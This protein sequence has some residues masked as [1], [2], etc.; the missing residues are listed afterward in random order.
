MKMKRGLF[1]LCGFVLLA[2]LVG[3]NPD[4]NTPAKL[5]TGFALSSVTP[6]ISP[7]FTPQP[8]LTSFPTPSPQQ[9]ELQNTLDKYECF[10]NFSES[11]SK[12]WR[13]YDDCNDL[14]RDYGNSSVLFNMRSGDSWNYPYCKYYTPYLDEGCPVEGH[15]QPKAWSTDGKYLYVSMT[16]GG[17]G[18]SYFNYV[19]KLISINLHNTLASVFL[20]SVAVFE[21]SPN[22][23]KLAY[24]TM[25]W[26]D[27]DYNWT[28]KEPITI[29]VRNL[30]SQS[31]YQMRLESGYDDA[32]DINWS[33]SDSQ[34]TFLA[35]KFDNRSNIENSTLMLMDVSKRSREILIEDYPGYLEFQEWLP[36][37]VLIYK[38]YSSGVTNFI[39]Y[40]IPDRQM[41]ITPMP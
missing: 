8:T 6:T 35:V 33:P 17:D 38:T 16:S 14:S 15:L 27:S 30:D 25:E 21:F 13:F 26:E 1:F 11:P 37:G 36:E 28:R 31:E 40:S 2:G 34:F 7:S 29:F 9:E 24:I 5:K 12:E 10:S 39:T 32:G 4:V 18:G 41:V 23:D 20:D 22:V 3:C 19:S